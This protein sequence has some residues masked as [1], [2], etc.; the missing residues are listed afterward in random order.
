MLVFDLMMY[1]YY[2]KVL[3]LMKLMSTLSYKGDLVLSARFRWTLSG[4]IKHILSFFKNP[5]MQKK[6]FTLQ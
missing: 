1:Y 5:H 2:L 6:W 3:K 4:E